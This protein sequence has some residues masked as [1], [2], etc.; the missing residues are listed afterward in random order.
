MIK[1]EEKG[2]DGVGLKFSV[3]RHDR[4]KTETECIHSVVC[5]YILPLESFKIK[6]DFQIRIEQRSTE[7]FKIAPTILHMNLATV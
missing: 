3:L 1:G 4:D 2:V 6:K 7:S 5:I